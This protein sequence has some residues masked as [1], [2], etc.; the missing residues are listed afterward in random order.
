MEKITCLIKSWE[1]NAKHFMLSLAGRKTQLHFL[2]IWFSSRTQLAAHTWNSSPVRKANLQPLRAGVPAELQS[3]ACSGLHRRSCRAGSS[4]LCHGFKGLWADH[5]RTQVYRG[6]CY[7][8]KTLWLAKITFPSAGPS[9]TSGLVS[10]QVWS[11]SQSVKP[12]H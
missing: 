9:L 3:A 1:D 12:K 5:L 8:V 2:T 4:V 11:L 6:L 7:T 10:S